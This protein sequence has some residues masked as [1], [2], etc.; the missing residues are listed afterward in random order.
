MGSTVS[1][2][3]IAFHKIAIINSVLNEDYENISKHL[4]YLSSIH[5][6]NELNKRFI[7]VNGDNCVSETYIS[8]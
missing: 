8:E 5:Y 3:L 6:L 4:E 1:K 7:K 2:K